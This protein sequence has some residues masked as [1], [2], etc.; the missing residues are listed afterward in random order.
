L[1]V[2]TAA[3][4]E[5]ASTN[6]SIQ[7][8]LW[9]NAGVVFEPQ[10]QVPLFTDILSNDPRWNS[11]GKFYVLASSTFDADLTSGNIMMFA[12]VEFLVPFLQQRANFGYGEAVANNGSD[13]ET[14]NNPLGITPYVMPGSNLGLVYEMDPTSTSL[15]ITMPPGQF[16]VAAKVAGVGLTS[17][18]LGGG[19]GV[20]LTAIGL[21]QSSIVN[22]GGTAGLAVWYIYVDPGATESRRYVTLSAAGTSV[23]TGSEQTRLWFYRGPAF[24]TPP[25]PL[26]LSARLDALERE[27]KEI[28]H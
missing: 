13:G 19:S 7:V 17:I 4:R 8:P 18:S 14:L 10:G 26:Q 20:T 6:C 11:F 2:G 5:A 9:A 28:T 12:E 3:L 1:G 27:L 16:V 24:Y 23:S 22:S 15:N 21:N 25:T